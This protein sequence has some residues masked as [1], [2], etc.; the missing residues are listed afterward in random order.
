MGKVVVDPHFGAD[1]SHHFCSSFFARCHV[2]KLLHAIFWLT[3]EESGELLRAIGSL[4]H[5]WNIQRKRILA[6]RGSVASCMERCLFLPEK[7]IF[8]G[9]LGKIFL[10]G[11]FGGCFWIG[12]WGVFF[13][14]G[15]RNTS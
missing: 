3:V 13:F 12:I 8:E 6:V 9:L 1:F 5:G 2:S 10:E 7:D 4:T 11:A 15:L 14:F